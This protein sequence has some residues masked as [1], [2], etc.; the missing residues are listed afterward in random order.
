MVA[1]TQKLITMKE[2]EM[3]PIEFVGNWIK[4]N[5]RVMLWQNNIIVKGYVYHS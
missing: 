4:V 3:K 2:Y 5:G 1:Q